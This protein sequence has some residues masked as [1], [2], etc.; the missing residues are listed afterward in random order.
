MAGLFVDQESLPL[1]Y[2]WWILT[3]RGFLAVLLGVA[4][5]GA[6]QL[7]LGAFLKLFAAYMILD[8][9][10]ALSYTIRNTLYSPI[11]TQHYIR[12]ILGVGVGTILLTWPNPTSFSLAIMIAVWAIIVGVYE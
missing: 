2:R 12:G 7:T 8:G 9:A 4:M 1:S 11:A 6:P 3:G 5:I 10:C